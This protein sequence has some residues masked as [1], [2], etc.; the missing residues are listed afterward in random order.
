MLENTTL[1]TA[2]ETYNVT[3][4]LASV[5]GNYTI[6]YYNPNDTSTTWTSYTPGVGGILTTFN[7]QT[8]YRPYWIYINVTNERLQIN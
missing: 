1:S 8:G 2:S 5:A 6:I 7:D 3:N 4:V